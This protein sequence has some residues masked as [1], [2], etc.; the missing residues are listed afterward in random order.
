MAVKIIRQGKNPKDI[1]R[2]GECNNC[3]TVFTFTRADAEIVYDQRDGD[4]L[5]I[6]CPFCKNDVTTGI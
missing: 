3:H 6:A 1:E 5:R 2:E 4:F